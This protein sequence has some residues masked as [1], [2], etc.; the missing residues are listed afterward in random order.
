MGVR[1][2]HSAGIVHLDIKYGLLEF[3]AGHTGRALHTG[4]ALC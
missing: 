3:T 4:Q 1:F 2:F